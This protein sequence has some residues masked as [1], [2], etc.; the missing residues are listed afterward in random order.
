[1]T[2]NIRS[3]CSSN[4][5]IAQEASD[6]DMEIDPTNE[7]NSRTS[8]DKPSNPKTNF[9]ISSFSP[10]LAFIFTVFTSRLKRETAKSTHHQPVVEQ[11]LPIK[12]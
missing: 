3:F 8:A 2:T 6:R 11:V 1:M 9:L 4:I 5:E 12:L 7:E 10:K